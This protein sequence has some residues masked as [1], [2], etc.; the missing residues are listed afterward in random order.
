MAVVASVP[1]LT[2][3]NGIFTAAIAADYEKFLRLSS[4]ITGF[5]ISDLNTD[6]ANTLLGLLLN[7]NYN[8]HLTSA[9]NTPSVPIDDELVEVIVTFWYAGVIV[10]DGSFSVDTYIEALMWKCAWFA[11]PKSVCA[12]V[13]ND[14]SVP[15]S[16]SDG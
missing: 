12:P 5:P 14:W 7:S 13:P 3:S 2:I 8:P 4:D 6:R 9:L 15:P 1:V 16:A 11:S 10:I